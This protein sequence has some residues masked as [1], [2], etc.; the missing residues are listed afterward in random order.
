MSVDGRRA[1]IAFT[2]EALQRVHEANDRLGARAVVAMHLPLHLVMSSVP[3]TVA[4]D[5][6]SDSLAEMLGWRWE[7][8][9][10]CP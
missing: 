2:A 9:Q 6:F 8:V 1:A 7:G 10:A 3:A 5:R 4:A